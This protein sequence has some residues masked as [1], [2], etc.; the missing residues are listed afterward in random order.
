[1]PEGDS[2]YRAAR[3]LQR[4]LGGRIV[5]AFETVLPAL[6]RVHQDRPVTGR[7]V[8]R[9]WSQ[10]KHLLIGFSGGLVLRTHMRMNGSWHVYRPGETWQRPRG[11]MRIVIGTDAFVAVAFTVPIAVFLEGPAV[12]RDR[13]LRAL[14]PDLLA[15]DFSVEDAVERLRARADVAIADALLDQR[16]L[17][18]IGNVFKS[19]VCFVCRADPFAPVVAFSDDELRTLVATAQ[20]LLR[21]NVTDASGGGI[22]TYRGLRGASRHASPGDRVW[23]Y[24]RRGKP[25][26]RC[27]A[28]IRARRQGPDARTTY[29]CAVCQGIGK[30]TGNEQ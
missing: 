14:G 15:A 19:E 8:E 4:A 25:C 12:T 11:D 5:T 27:G 9:V 16:A 28:T 29:W 20:A 2:I 23:V 30:L 1:M 17:A 18:G 3:T 24:G 10:G 21:G 7:T 13:T 26:R 22:V 6:D